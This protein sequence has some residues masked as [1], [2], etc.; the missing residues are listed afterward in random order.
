VNGLQV[1]IIKEAL[2]TPELLTEWEVEFIQNIANKH[3]DVDLTKKQ[4]SV[5]NKIWDKLR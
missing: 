4:N 2:E 3:E 1:K 5:L